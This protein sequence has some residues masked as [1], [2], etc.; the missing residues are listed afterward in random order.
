MPDRL[1]QCYSK[2][3]QGVPNP[4]TFKVPPPLEGRYCPRPGCGRR[5]SAGRDGPWCWCGYVYY[6]AA[7]PV[8]LETAS[9]LPRNVSRWT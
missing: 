9:E 5:L 3:A 8:L 1:G 4:S 7:R 6:T 2:A